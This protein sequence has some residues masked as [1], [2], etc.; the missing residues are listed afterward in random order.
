LSSPV[1]EDADRRTKNVS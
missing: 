1:V